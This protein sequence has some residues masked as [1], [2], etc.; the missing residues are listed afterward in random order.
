M[1]GLNSV[2]LIGNLVANAEVRYT[3]TNQPVTSC[4]LACTETYFS[5]GEKKERTEF[6]NAVIWGKRG[7]ALVKANC[8]N[9]GQSLYVE[10]HLQTRS[11][12]DQKGNKRYT[13]EV[14][15][16]LSD[17]ALQLLGRRREAQNTPQDDAPPPSDADVPA[18]DFTE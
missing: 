9:K 4:R 7:Q 10:G 6:V 13:T 16:G 2:R 14:V 17:Q 12:D 18:E 11:W 8:L 1:A 15:V 3:Q 5:R